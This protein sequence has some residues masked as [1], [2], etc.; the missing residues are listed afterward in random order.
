MFQLR[1]L[2]SRTS[3]PSD[4]TNMNAA[5]DFL[6]LLLHTH[7]V[8]AAKTVLAYN[9]TESVTQ[10]ADYIVANFIKLPELS[11]KHDE[12]PSTREDDDDQDPED[13]DVHCYVTEL[14]TLSLLWHGF[15]DAIKEGDG[16]RILRYWKFL[17]VIFKSSNKYNYAKESVNLLL[18]YY[19]ILSER[20]REQLIW[21]RCVNTKG[22]KG[23]NI[24]CDLYMEH[25][26][27]RLKTVLRY[28][29]ANIN[30]SSVQKAGKS[31]GAV[32][33]VCQIF[34]KQTSSCQ[35]SDH[36]SFP[37]FGKD[38]YTILKEL[39]EGN[40][41][42]PLC[43]RQHD[44]FKIKQGLMNKFSMEELAKKVKTNIDQIY[45]P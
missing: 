14:L 7:C 35:S 36:H 1:N 8:A 20:Q 3:V 27:R 9:P 11:S 31:I 18:Q 2:I 10:L 26:N 17:L 12:D 24:P 42:V 34:E 37:A 25:L 4:P 19:Y 5:E 13:D 29:G 23:A 6:L 28:L 40:V 21:S 16:E 41:F 30:P 22:Y 32:H 45:Y 15:H 39:E 33:H 43:K 38:Y 44:S